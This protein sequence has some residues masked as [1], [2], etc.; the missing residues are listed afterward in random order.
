MRGEPFCDGEFIK[1]L[2]IE[3]ASIIFKKYANKGKIIQRIKGLPMTKNTGIKC[4]TEEI[5]SSNSLSK[6]LSN[7]IFVL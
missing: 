7:A 4:I 2:M 3:T 1:N 5:T 6:N